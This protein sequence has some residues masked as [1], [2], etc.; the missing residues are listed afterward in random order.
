MSRRRPR[1]SFGTVVSHL[2]VIVAVSVVLGVLT[3][4]LVV[5]AVGALGYA[6][7]ATDKSMKNL[8]RS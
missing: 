2:G 5:P 4:G 7:S 8:P 1:P 3:A 6:A